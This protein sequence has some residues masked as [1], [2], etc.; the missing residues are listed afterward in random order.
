MPE[1]VGVPMGVGPIDAVFV[2]ASLGGPAAIGEVLS[3]LPADFPVPVAVC[4]HISKG[5]TRVL[6]DRLDNACPLEVHEAADGEVFGAGHI[7]VAPSGVHMRVR[8]THEGARVRLD[9]DFADSLHVP[10][11]DVLMSSAA[12]AFGSCALA[13]LLTGMGSDGAL[14]MYA[15][16]KA[17]GH[18]ICEAEE[19]AVSYSMPK[20]A[21]ELGAAAEQAPIEEIAD[22]IL[23]RMEGMRAEQEDAGDR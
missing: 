19:T 20:S 10:S 2:G 11:I 14:G 4:Q 15:V 12:Q 5:F 21:V 13:V 9:E 17:G 6:V 7:Y 23:S 8:K 3:R 16:R 18:T 22:R 1:P